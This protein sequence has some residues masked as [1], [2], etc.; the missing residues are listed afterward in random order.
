[1]KRNVGKFDLFV[2]LTTKE[3]NDPRKGKVK[4]VNLN[5]S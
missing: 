5:F 4:G 1:M 3:F 2:V